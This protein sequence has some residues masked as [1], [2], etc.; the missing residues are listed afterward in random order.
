MEKSVATEY[1]KKPHAVPGFWAAAVLI[2]FAASVGAMYPPAGAA[3][4]AAGRPMT[5]CGAGLS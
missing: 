1:T 2:A 3:A 4:A 5:S